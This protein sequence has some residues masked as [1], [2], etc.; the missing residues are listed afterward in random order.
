MFHE[1][2]SE[3]TNTGFAPRYMTGF[4]LAQNVKLWQITSS[5]AF[6]PTAI[7]AR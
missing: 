1:L 4:E 2:L 6:T 7:K 5:P 3:S